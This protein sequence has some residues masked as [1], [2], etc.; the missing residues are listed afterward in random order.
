MHTQVLL[1]KHSLRILLDHFQYILL[2]EIIII[3]TLNL[4][5]KQYKYI[6]AFYV[7]LVLEF[8]Y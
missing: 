3:R 6:V 2:I 8:Y 7:Y 4:I 5:R 1:W